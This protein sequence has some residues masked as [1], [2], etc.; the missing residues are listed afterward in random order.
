MQPCSRVHN[1]WPINPKHQKT[2]TARVE[3][4][5][6]TVCLNTLWLILYVALALVYVWQCVNVFTGNSIFF[7]AAHTDPVHRQ[8]Q[9][10][11]TYLLL[12]TYLCV[13]R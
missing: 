11:M 1:P 6:S 8:W 9:V 4:V 7:L 12:L 2:D 13:Y 3:P 5:R 10:V